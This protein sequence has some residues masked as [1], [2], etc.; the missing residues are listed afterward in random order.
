M[1]KKWKNILNVCYLL[2]IS[3]H[4]LTLFLTIHAKPMQSLAYFKFSLMC[5][6]ASFFFENVCHWNWPWGPSIND[7]GNWEGSKLSTDSTKKL[8]TWGRE[9]SK[10]RKK[11]PTSFMN[12]P[13]VNFEL[14]LFWIHKQCLPLI[15]FWHIVFP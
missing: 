7:V 6:A 10:I 8:P 14:H 3:E 15:L 11:L 5:A 1:L 9:V 4:W 2:K 13:L 12:G